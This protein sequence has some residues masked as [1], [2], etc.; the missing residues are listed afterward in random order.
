M[1]QFS[2]KQNLILQKYLSLSSNYVICLDITHLGVQGELL[3]AI[4][5]AARTKAKL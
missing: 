3:L 2:E 5:L 4:D 1:T